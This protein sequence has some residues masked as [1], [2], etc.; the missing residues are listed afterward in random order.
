[1]RA[2]GYSAGGKCGGLAECCVCGSDRTWGWPGLVL[3]AEARVE[4][5]MLLDPSAVAADD[6]AVFRAG[7]L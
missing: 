2:A 5:K 7:V 1:M 4:Q 6:L 3:L